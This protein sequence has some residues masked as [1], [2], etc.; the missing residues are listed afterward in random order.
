MAVLEMTRIA[1]TSVLGGT[2]ARIFAAVSSWSEARATR[3]MLS[4]LSDRELEDIG[5][6]RGDIEAITARH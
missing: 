3:K 4:S 6:A 2:V 5:L 1:H